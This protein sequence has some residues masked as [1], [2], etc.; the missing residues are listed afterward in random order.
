VEEYLA[1]EMYPL[2]AGVG[3]EKVTNGVTPVLRLKLPLPKFRIERKDDK[4]DVQFVE[5]VELE[6]KS[7]AV[8]YSRPAHDV[9]VAGLLNGG[10]LNRVF[11]L[12]GV[13]YRP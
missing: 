11:E 7:V 9:C 4:D 5:R 2:S 12:V 1:C 13:P 10:R 8:S 3:F 6:M